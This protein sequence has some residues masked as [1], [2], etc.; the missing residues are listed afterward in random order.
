[1]QARK[2]NR[3]H[4]ARCPAREQP[5]SRTLPGKGTASAARAAG[6]RGG[7][8]ASSWRHCGAAS[9]PLAVKAA[10]RWTRQG[11]ARQGH[12]TRAQAGAF[13]QLH[14]QQ[15]DQ[16]SCSTARRNDAAGADATGTH[17]S[18]VDSVTPVLLP[19]FKSGFK[20]PHVKGK[21]RKLS[22][23]NEESIFMTPETRKD[24]LPKS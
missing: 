21:T 14:Q 10:L 24:V 4:C 13:T 20:D 15:D 2:G 7:Q 8:P 11:H 5:A 6:R 9:L 22:K 3:Q 18:S 16:V 1:M 19:F 12:R 17:C 23:Q